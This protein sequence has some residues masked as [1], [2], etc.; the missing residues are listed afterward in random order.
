[1]AIP[2][3]RWSVAAALALGVHFLA[4][5]AA[6]AEEDHLIGFKIKDLNAVP[7]LAGVAV[8]ADFG[9]ETCDLKRPE[10]ML[11]KSEKSGG[12]DP[13]GGTAG[14]FVCYKARCTG[15]VPPTVT[16]DS[17]FGVHAIESKKAKLVCLPLNQC[18]DGDVD[19]GEECDGADNSACPGL[20][21]SDCTC[22]P[23]NMSGFGVCPHPQQIC[24]FV[25]PQLGYVCT[26]GTCGPAPTCGGSCLSGETCMDTGTTD[27]TCLQ[28]Q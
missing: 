28:F 14:N 15:A 6:R 10:F 2:G 26:S 24:V 9:N 4:V 22:T 13:R 23:C 5:G 7:G 27:C 3:R 19:P 11:V 18:G 25:A 16:T 20:C 17:Q 8:T 21:R 12:D 1:M